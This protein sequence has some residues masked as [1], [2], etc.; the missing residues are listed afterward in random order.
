MIPRGMSPQPGASIRFPF[1]PL[2]A[3]ATLLSAEQKCIVIGEDLGTV[4]EH[5]R[6]TLAD[7]GLWSYQ[8]M[9]FERTG[10]GEFVPP[11]SYRRNALV[12]FGTHDVPTFVGWRDHHDLAIKQPIGIDPGETSEQRA[13]AVEALRHA[14]DHPA[15][16]AV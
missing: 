7:W 12:S 6:E 5:F 13:R 4:P 9:M 3:I 2:L 16:Q 10:Q 15:D 11:G 14:L 8:V 1:E